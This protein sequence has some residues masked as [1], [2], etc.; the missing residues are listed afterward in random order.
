MDISTLYVAIAIISLLAIMLILF[1]LGKRKP[2]AT[3]TPLGGIA[4]VFIIAGIVFG[5]NRW[6][7]Y[8][9]MGIGVV[10]AIIDAVIRRR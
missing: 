4:F 3:L 8:S 7:G 6:I 2:R 1:V 5:D 10:I 9:L